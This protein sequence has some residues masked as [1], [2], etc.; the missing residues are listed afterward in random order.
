MGSQNPVPDDLQFLKEMREDDPFVFNEKIS[1]FA[2]DTAIEKR[3]NCA[4]SLSRVASE[5]KMESLNRTEVSNYFWVLSDLLY[6][7]SYLR[8]KVREINKKNNV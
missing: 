4:A 8:E 6:Q 2:L 1:V 7:V 3:I 5:C